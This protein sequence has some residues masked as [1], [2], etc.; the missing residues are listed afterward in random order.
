MGQVFNDCRSNKATENISMKQ[1]ERRKRNRKSNFYYSFLLLPREKRQAVLTLYDFC[2]QTDDIIDNNDSVARKSSALRDWKEIFIR[3]LNGER[4]TSPLGDL[5]S[6]VRKFKIPVELCLELIDG[7]AMDLTKHRYRSFEELYLYCYRVGS[8]V[9]LMSI[10]IFGYRDSKS[11]Q[12]AENLGIALQL[13]N[14][15][16]DIK[17]DVREGR[18]YLPQEDLAAFGYTEDCLERQ[19]VNTQFESLIRFECERARSYF[20]LAQSHLSATDLR[21]LYP[22][23]TMARIYKN[24]LGQIERCPSDVW[25]R[26]VRVSSFSK[27]ALA[28]RT[29]I[30][31]KSKISYAI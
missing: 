28:V 12:Y 10:E 4:I 23:E 19:V 17:S 11:K 30:E 15:L 13:T 6:V 5:V 2:R 26:D 22:A 21:T 25:R 24:I 31:H 9:G 27:L 14:I 16:R 7:V 18:I 20:R 3:S 1:L 29:W 8:T